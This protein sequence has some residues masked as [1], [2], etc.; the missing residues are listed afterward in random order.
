MLQTQRTGTAVGRTPLALDRY[1]QPRNPSRAAPSTPDQSME[2]GMLS[3]SQPAAP[4]ASTSDSSAAASSSQTRQSSRLSSQTRRRW[5]PFGDAADAGNTAEF[6][7]PA[8]A[9]G[10]L[11]RLPGSRAFRL[12]GSLNRQ[13]R[14]RVGPMGSGIWT[15]RWDP[16]RPVLIRPGRINLSPPEQ[17]RNR[18]ACAWRRPWT[19][20]DAHPES[21]LL[22][23]RTS[24]HPEFQHPLHHTLE[25]ESAHHDLS[26]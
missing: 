23:G 20:R 26:T 18:P 19:H 17:I 12:P 6:L 2:S 1:G 7:A 4:A 10:L 22:K 5:G 11:R 14:I 15:A 25:A 13:D 3:A 24:R 8:M 16:G 9:A 21:L